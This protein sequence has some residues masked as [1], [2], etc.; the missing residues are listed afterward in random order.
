M[1]I[2]IWIMTITRVYVPAE[3]CSSQQFNYE[4]F[5]NQKWLLKLGW[6]FLFFFWHCTALGGIISISIK[7]KTK[8]QLKIYFKVINF[9]VRSINCNL[10]PLIIPTCTDLERVNFTLSIL[11]IN[12][13]LI[14]SSLNNDD[15]VISVIKFR[16]VFGVKTCENG[17]EKKRRHRWESAMSCLIELTATL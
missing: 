17:E 4:Q 14:S 8:F 10:T 7:L 3:H 12:I 13:S 9:S 2:K 15:L 16:C 11:S 5:K 6:R 1:W